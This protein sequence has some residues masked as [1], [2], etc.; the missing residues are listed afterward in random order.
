MH[1]KAQNE[2]QSKTPAFSTSFSVLNSG[3][4]T[5]FL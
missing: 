1:E 2:Q 3:N 4:A 5:F